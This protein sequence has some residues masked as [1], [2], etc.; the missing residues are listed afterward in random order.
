MKGA[1]RG[2]S[3]GG[4]ERVER[5]GGSQSEKKKRGGK[6]R[7]SEKRERKKEGEREVKHEALRGLLVC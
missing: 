7:E 4:R 2:E 3:E 6:V 5:G 1:N